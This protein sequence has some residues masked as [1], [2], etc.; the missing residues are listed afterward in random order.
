MPLP[1]QPPNI[2]EPLGPLPR[3]FAA[4]MRPELPGL[5]KEIRVEVTRA[6]PEY[7][8]L[9]NGP[10]AAAIRQGVEKSLSVFVDRVADPKAST[11]A[12][13]ELLRKF[14][15]VEAY[16]GRDLE[17]LQSAYRLG[18]RV[19]L[20]RAKTIGRR[21]DLSPTLLLTFADA[22]FAYVDELESLSR[23]GYAEVQA[24]AGA[25]GEAMRRRLLHLLL[26]GTP[27]THTTIHELCEQ[28]GW[29]LPDQVT[30]I[31]LRAPAPDHIQAGLPSDVLAD[32]GAPQP[33]LLIP[34]PMT[35]ERTA[36]LEDAVAGTPL[37]VGLTV[38][39]A[40]A[41]DSLRWARRLLQLVDDDIVADAPVLDTADHLVTL[42]LLSDPALV[43]EI[44]TRALAPLNKSSGARRARL[45]ETLHAW[46][47]TRGT[48]DQV[49]EA[50]GVHAQT[51]RYRLRNLESHFG[52]SL[53][54]PERRFAMEAALRALHL[55]GEV[56]AGRAPVPAGTGDA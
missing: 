26:A 12:R 42:W 25:A 36:L 35:A 31:A 15:R 55:H 41:A 27:L 17:T 49:G 37:A 24:R 39:T 13:D 54:N 14:G 20:R 10:N 47:T 18:A 29:P 28:L 11:A 43:S 40:R 46:L 7:A 45:V 9:L 52:D 53:E 56:T 44:A 32:L 8:Q 51:V 22:L 5:I 34:G 6:Y 16:E 33:H 23:E 38:P 1:V 4:I 19:A 50:L 30:L 48:A 3:E 21:F 2:N